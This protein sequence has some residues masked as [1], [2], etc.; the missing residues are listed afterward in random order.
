VSEWAAAAT[1]A[2]SFFL[3]A[4]SSAAAGKKKDGRS[5]L[6][7]YKGEVLTVGDRVLLHDIF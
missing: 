2:P 3:A 5:M 1:S 6:R 7:H 4:H